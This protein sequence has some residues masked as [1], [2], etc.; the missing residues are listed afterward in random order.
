MRLA[1]RVTPRS[2]RDA[3]EGWALDSAGRPFLN[4]RVTAAPADGAANAAVIALVAKALKRPKS[5]IV[6][7]S[8]ATA[9]LKS[10]EIGEVSPEELTAALGSLP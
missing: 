10:L 4:L 3:I 8:G 6:L 2:G 9:R 1:V 5:Q 7:A